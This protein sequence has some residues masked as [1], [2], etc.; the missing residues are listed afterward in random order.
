MK[1]SP[2]SKRRPIRSART[3]AEYDFRGGVR[4]KYAAAYSRGTN[5]V[6]LAPD[7]A[8]HFRSATSV[9]RVLRRY[10]KDRKKKP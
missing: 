7:V 1:K 8:D 9:N 4:G 6:L 5:L 2:K 10:L 3:R